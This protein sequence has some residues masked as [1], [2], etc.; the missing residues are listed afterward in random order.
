MKV[1]WCSSC[2]SPWLSIDRT[3]ILITTVR[4]YCR[5]TFLATRTELEIRDSPERQ[6]TLCAFKEFAFHK[7]TLLTGDPR[8]TSKWETKHTGRVLLKKTRLAIVSY[9]KRDDKLHTAF[10]NVIFPFPNDIASVRCKTVTL[11]ERCVV[12]TRV[13]TRA[14]AI[15]AGRNILLDKKDKRRSTSGDAAKKMSHVDSVQIICATYDND[16]AASIEYTCKQRQL[17]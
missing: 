7:E 12:G 6:Y 2:S 10:R 11:V 14:C 8:C 3:I 1:Y 15:F 17:F 9:V 4:P 5:C 16:H 13:R